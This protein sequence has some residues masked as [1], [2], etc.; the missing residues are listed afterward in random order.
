M[1]EAYAL[2]DPI[3]QFEPTNR[4]ILEYRATLKDY[5]S[6]GLD[7]DAADEDE[8][9]DDDEADSDSNDDDDDDDDNDDDD[10]DS[11]EEV[12]GKHSTRDAR[13]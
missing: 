13:K 10:L 9:D 6:Q 3:L 7:D 12:E 11:D 4:I 5:I 1:K 8:D 2:C